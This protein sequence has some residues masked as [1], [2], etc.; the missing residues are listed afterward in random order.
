V[1]LFILSKGRFSFVLSK[2]SS[3][4][5]KFKQ[6]TRQTPLGW[7]WSTLFYVLGPWVLDF[8]CSERNL[9]RIKKIFYTR[10]FDYPFHPTDSSLSHSF[11][12]FF[13]FYFY[14]FL[15]NF[16]RRRI[17][18]SISSLPNSST[19]SLVP[20]LFSPCITEPNRRKRGKE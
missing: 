17:K 9:F 1:Q 10:W 4:G 7:A 2:S 14:F 19:L 20:C 18:L 8:V 16:I 3:V 15:W 5:F 6:K 11:S 12:F 13:L